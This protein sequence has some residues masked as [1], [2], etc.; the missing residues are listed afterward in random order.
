MGWHWAVEI[1]RLGHQVHILT[2]ANNVAGIERAL[3]DRALAPLDGLRLSVHGYDLP[4]SLRWWKRGQ[5]GAHLYYVFWQW[6]AYRRARA[7][8]RA[9]A[10]DLVHHITLAVY[11]HPSFM[12]RL[13]I[14]FVFGPVGGGEDTPPALRASLPLRGRVLDFLR[15]VAN[16]IAAI[17][18][19][20][21]A[22]LSQ[23]S[24]ILF[25]T[26]ETL[27]QFPRRFHAK[28]ICVQDVAAGEDEVALEP[29]TCSGPH[30]LFAGRLLYW[31]GIHLALR[32]LAQ[33]RAQMPGARLTIAGTGP[34]R[35]W[36]ERLARKLDLNDAVDWRG[37]LPREEVLR[38]YASHTAFVFPS[39][40]DS[41][42]TVVMEAIAQGLPVLCL[43]LGGPGA[44]LPDGCGM[45]IPARGRTEDE[46]IA[47]LAAAMT[48][49]A[50]DPSLR[51]RLAENALEAARR[52][53]WSALV[54]HTYAQIES[55]LMAEYQP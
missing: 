49:L 6:G 29:A 55:R 40:H 24:L 45:K 42:G 15:G 31:K 5:R 14:S 52:M 9:H 7:L 3:A 43:D 34:D 54:A 46:V 4:R 1:A 51:K 18:P 25:K 16:R 47:D 12:G 11:R 36:L 13:G 10:F 26:R 30:F 2:R 53:T 22:A 32:A 38:T 20:V 37:W 17:D 33:L 21:L 19:L 41:G 35:A 23:A 39:L 44:I 27:E 50:T 8:H 28:C 48:S